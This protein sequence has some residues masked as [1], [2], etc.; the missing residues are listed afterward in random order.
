MHFWLIKTEPEVWSWENQ[1]KKGIEKWNG[2]RNYQARNHMKAMKIGDL[3]LF[4]HT[5]EA[6]EIV[7]LVEVVK[8]HYPDENPNFVCIDVKIY[9]QLNKKVTLGEIKS[10]P[11]FQGLPLI[12]QSRLSVMPIDEE[13]YKE[14]MK[15]AFCS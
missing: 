5:G 9:K 8:E 15:M 11:S 1:K 10:N 3:A 4:Y 13:S 6:R 2:V 7:G 12:K 14:I